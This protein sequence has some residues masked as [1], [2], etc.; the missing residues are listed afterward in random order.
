M[1]H[2]KPAG[3]RCINLT[4]DN[5]CRIWGQPTYPKVCERFRPSPEVCGASSAEA[6]AI[7]ARL[8]SET[9]PDT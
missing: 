9:A 4:P 1:P 6:L 2:G 8:E 7:L 3:V 5:R